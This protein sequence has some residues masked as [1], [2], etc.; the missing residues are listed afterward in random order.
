MFCELLYILNKLREISMGSTNIFLHN[1]AK[2][3]YTAK[4]LFILC[5]K[6]CENRNTAFNIII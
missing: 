5:E 2:Q 1:M 3:E 4:V 6:N